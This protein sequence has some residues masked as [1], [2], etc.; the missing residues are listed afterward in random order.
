MDKELCG[1]LLIS[2]RIIT[3]FALRFFFLLLLFGGMVSSPT[4]SLVVSLL[5]L[6]PP[7]LPLSLLLPLH[8]SPLPSLSIG[9]L[10]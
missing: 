5:L 8:S 6:S 9:Q 10:Y 3:T 7:P 4:Y 2:F 1:V